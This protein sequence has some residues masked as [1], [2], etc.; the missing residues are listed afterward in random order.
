[1]TVSSNFTSDYLKLNF[2]DIFEDFDQYD[3]ILE[4]S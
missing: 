2:V 1:M 4:W 3:S